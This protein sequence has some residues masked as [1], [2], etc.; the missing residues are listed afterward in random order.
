MEG[1]ETSS[2]RRIPTNR[3]DPI[4]QRWLIAAQNEADRRGVHY[5]VSGLVLL[6]AA[7]AADEFARK[8]TEA[9]NVSQVSTLQDAFDREWEERSRLFLDQPPTIIREAIERAAAQ[10]PEP[11]HASPQAFIA[12]LL[13]FE[14][15]MATR[16]TKRLGGSPL[17]V[18]HRLRELTE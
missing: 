1:S 4:V 14:D 7:A 11:G 18:T 12:I 16:M 10:T 5:L 15:S 9:L 13:S 2:K 3:L 8:L 17:E 6:A